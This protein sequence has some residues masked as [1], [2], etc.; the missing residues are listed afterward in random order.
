MFRRFLTHR[1][2]FFYVL[3]CVVLVVF[4]LF[5]TRTNKEDHTQLKQ[6]DEISFALFSKPE[7]LD[8]SSVDV[9]VNKILFPIHMGLLT[10]NYKG[11]FYSGIAKSWEVSPDK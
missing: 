6:P 4:A 10:N 7:K 2:N 8:L 1:R 11:E 5:A 9:S 3:S